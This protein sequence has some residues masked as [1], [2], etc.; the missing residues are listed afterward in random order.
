[1]ALKKK[2]RRTLERVFAHPVPSG[3]RWAEI[4][5]LLLALGC[6]VVEAEGSRVRITLPSG[7]TLV[8]HRTHGLASGA[9]DKGSVATIRDWLKE[10]GIRP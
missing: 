3:L 5:G 6:T 2:H 8:H 1:M 10:N 9:Q 4:E 7:A